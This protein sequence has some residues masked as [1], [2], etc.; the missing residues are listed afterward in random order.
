M[1]KVISNS[2]LV[3]AVGYNFEDE[4]FLQ[5]LRG[6]IRPDTEFLLV[7]TQSLANNPTLHESYQNISKVWSLKE[8]SIF[9]E[10]DLGL[11]QI[12]YRKLTV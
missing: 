10:M 5:E 12:P 7:G 3:I 8:I 6:S 1:Q 2:A 4:R 11:L 9:R